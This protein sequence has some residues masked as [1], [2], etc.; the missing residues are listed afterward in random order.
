MRPI[1]PP[2]V[3]GLLI[4]GAMYVVARQVDVAPFAGPGQAIIAAA[5]VA[6]GLA[7]EGV[8]VAAFFRAKT[9]INPL[10]PARA[11]KLVIE[12]LY[13]FS[14]NPMYLG[15]LIMLAGVFAYLGEGLN[16][17]AL[18]LFVI[19]INELQIKPEERALEAKFGEDYRAYR[20][21][22]RRWI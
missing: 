15:M 1:I 9:T 16:A 5:L 10:A 21:R 8:S 7:I 2:P 11:E 18:A 13:K 14:R 4:A 19:L 20:Q 3:L 17:L 22:V 12:G 6:I